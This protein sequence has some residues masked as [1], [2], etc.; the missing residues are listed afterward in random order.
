[1]GRRAE[2]NFEKDRRPI[3]ERAI[4][5]HNG[6]LRVGEIEPVERVDGFQEV[7]HW[8]DQ[9]HRGR[10]RKDKGRLQVLLHSTGRSILSPVHGFGNDVDSEQPENRQRSQRKVQED[11]DRGDIARSRSEQIEGHEVREFERWA[12]EEAEHRVGVDRQSADHV[13]RRADHRPRLPVLQPMHQIVTRS[14]ENRENHRLHHP[15]AKRRYI[16]DVRLRLPFGGWEML[17]QRGYE[18]HDSLFRERWPPLSQI[19]QSGRFHDRGCV[20]GIRQFQRSIDR[21]GSE[22]KGRVLANDGFAR[23]L[24]EGGGGGERG[25]GE[26]FDGKS[27]VEPATLGIRETLRS[28]ESLHDPFVQ[29]LDQ[30]LFEIGPSLLDGR[31]ARFAVLRGRPGREQKYQQRGHGPSSCHLSV[32]HEHDAC[33]VAIPV[34]D[35]RAEEG[36]IQQL[37]QVED[38]LLRL[39]HVHPAHTNNILRR[40]RSA[41]LFYKPATAR[42]K[43]IPH[44]LDTGNFDHPDIGKRRPRH[45]LRPKSRERHIFRRHSGVQYASL[46]GF[47]SP[48]QSYATHH[49]L[50]QLRKLPKVFPARHRSRD[51]RLQSGEIVLPDHILPL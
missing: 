21:V 15:P 29:G 11:I 48:F 49:V 3:Q 31:V 5:G 27:R 22:E 41:H 42:R 16:R 24:E 46:L 19:P 40:L 35:A 28:D 7:L 47:H 43:Q 17:V 8:P 2:E 23:N 37:V 50:Y 26:G 32:L 10:G 33:R 13:S 1:M 51:I 12:K 9:I 6:P 20:Q 38:L 30:H 36:T 25:M 18:G 39:V 34:G 4:V 45:R 14:G 44:V